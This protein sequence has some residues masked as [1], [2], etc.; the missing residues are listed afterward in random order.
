MKNGII[1]VLDIAEITF[2]GDNNFVIIVVLIAD[3]YVNLSI[4]I[5]LL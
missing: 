2:L 4:N 1:N 3:D 5:F